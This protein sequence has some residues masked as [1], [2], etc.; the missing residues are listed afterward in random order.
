MKRNQL[1]YGIFGVAAVLGLVAMT[2]VGTGAVGGR[3]A[4]AAT[5]APAQPQQAAVTPAAPKPRID[6]A[7]V[8]DTTGSMEELIEGAKQKIWSIASDI[9]R[10]QPTPELRVGLVAYRDRGDAYVTRVFPLTANL[11][12]VYANLKTLR[13]AGGG[14]TP[15]DVRAALL[16]GI[17][18]MQWSEGD[19]VL[20]LLFLV[21]DSPP[22]AY[23]DEPDEAAIAS[24]ATK[25]GIAINAV[26][27]GGAGE[28]EK[29]WKVIASAADGVYVSIDQGGGMAAV[30]TPMD[31]RL[32][33]LNAELSDTAVAFGEERDRR[34]VEGRMIANKAMATPIQADSAR[35]RAASKHVDTNDLVAA[36][37]S[38]K[39]DLDAIPDEK[40]PE[41]LRA[42]PKPA[43]KGWVNA[44]MAKRKAVSTEVLELST[45]RD[46]YLKAEQAKRGEPDG[47]DAE[48]KKAIG[49]KAAK[50]GV[51]Y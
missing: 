14:D 46:E 6:L 16:A 43:L 17:R 41:E 27:C 8:L 42:M 2:L 1:T 24:E 10:G 31:A 47:F 21:G 15:E 28:T 9:A 25:K 45:R 13:A 3:P 51:G 34:A 20:R 40:L 22:H 30:P 48:V 19:Q 38:G 39:A 49:K 50:I 11:D 12:E 33:A 35:F 37:E 36:V 18:Q 5:P 32:A 26:R 29:V 23:K 44:K 7:F 4:R